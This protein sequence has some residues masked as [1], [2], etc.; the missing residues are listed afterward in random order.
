MRC[1]AHEK[2][3][4]DAPVSPLSRT[5][6]GTVAVQTDDGVTGN[7]EVRRMEERTREL[8]RQLDRKTFEVEIV[9]EALVR[10]R[11]KKPTLVSPLT[12]PACPVKRGQLQPS[13]STAGNCV[14]A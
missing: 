14:A 7:G 6:R 3:H 12:K 4:D 11:A 8:G 2:H 13:T 5:L 10:S 1:T 9:N